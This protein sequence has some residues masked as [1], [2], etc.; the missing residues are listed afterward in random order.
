MLHGLHDTCGICFRDERKSIVITNLYGIC[1]A[2]GLFDLG[3]GREV[4][5]KRFW[6][7]T[8]YYPSEFDKLLLLSPTLHSR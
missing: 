2:S 6:S 8:R 4:D 7:S 1:R 3:K 5:E